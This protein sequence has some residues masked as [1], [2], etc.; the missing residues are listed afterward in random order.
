MQLKKRLLWIGIA[1]GAVI[2]IFAASLAT[3]QYP[4]FYVCLT[5][6]TN[7][8]INYSTEWCTRAGY[9]CSGYR[10]WTLSPGDSRTHWGDAGNGRMDVRI[11]TGGEGGAWQNYTFHG[12]EGGCDGSRYIRYNSRGFLRIN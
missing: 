2:S 3:A 9:N 11:H 1:C 8:Y 10:S 4:V 12:A 7:A 6:N 5:N